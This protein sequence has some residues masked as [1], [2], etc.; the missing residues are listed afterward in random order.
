MYIFEIMLPAWSMGWGRSSLHLVAAGGDKEHA[1]LVSYGGL[2][3]H[4]HGGELRF[5]PPVPCRSL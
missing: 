3:W 5:L 4:G 1:G 2:G